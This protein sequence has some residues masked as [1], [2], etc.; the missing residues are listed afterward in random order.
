[1]KQRNYLLKVSLM[2]LF[3]FMPLLSQAATD[4]VFTWKNVPLD[5]T[6][7]VSCFFTLIQKFNDKFYAFSGSGKSV[8]GGR[9]FGLVNSS[10]G[11]KWEQTNGSFGYDGDS[12]IT[13]ATVWTNNNDN[14]H[15]YVAAANIG[16]G[17]NVYRSSNGE[18]WQRVIADGLDSKNNDVINH[19]LSFNN[20]IYAFTE[21][22]IDDGGSGARMFVSDTG[23]TGE[24]TVQKFS[25]YMQAPGIV[26][27]AVI[28]HTNSS[29][30][31]MPYLYIVTGNASLYRTS[32]GEHWTK[33]PFNIWLNGYGTNLVE[34]NGYLYMATFG[35][36][37]FT[38]T[39]FTKL[40]RSQEPTLYGWEEI[41]IGITSEEAVT[42]FARKTKDDKAKYLYFSTYPSGYMFRIGQNTNQV[43]RISE[44]YLGDPSAGPKYVDAILI[45]KNTFYV[46]G[47]TAKA[48]TFK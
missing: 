34:F 21:N 24:W 45:G 25:E 5:I 20:K 17:A 43:E 3:L 9:A 35:T 41:D 15:I 37:M 38:S 47:S 39:N 4:N 10:D 36:N 13:S 14:K 27:A 8:D 1:M 19:I 40:F 29:G 28:N 32:D 46:Y 11:I 44:A 33:L 22:D 26:S 48:F 23:K 31:K 12:D 7:N 18:S 6:G 42:I 16:S 30:G 2:S